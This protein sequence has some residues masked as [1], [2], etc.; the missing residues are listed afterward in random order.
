ML[1]AE[2]KEPAIYDQLYVLY[3]SGGRIEDANALLHQKIE[4]F[5]RVAEYRIQLAAH[6]VDL[7]KPIES[8]KALQFVVDNRGEFPKADMH[9][10]DYYVKTGRWDDAIKQFEQGVRY[11][12]KEKSLYQK[13]IFEAYLAQ[14]KVAAANEVLDAMLKDDPKNAEARIAKAMLRLG[15]MQDAELK[16]AIKDFQALS[17]EFPDNAEY[18]FNLG[19]AYTVMEDL[20][21]ALKELSEAIRLNPD[22]IQARI[23]AAEV[24]IEKQSFKDALQQA[25]EVLSR[26]PDHPQARLLRIGALLGQ[27]NMITARTELERLLRDR[28]DFSAAEIQLAY[29]E[30]QAKRYPEAEQILRKFYRP[31]TPDLLVLRGLATLYLARGQADRA[32]ELLNQEINSSKEPQMTSRMR[33]V[34]AETATH[35]GKADIAVQQY[36]RALPNSRRPADIYYR[37][38]SL[39]A[40]QSKVDEAIQHLQQARHLAPE[41]SSIQLSLAAMLETKGRLEEAQPLYKRVLKTDPDNA[42]ALNNLAFNLAESGGDL[43][44][45]LRLINRALKRMPSN[46]NLSD[47]LGWIYLKKKDVESALPIML[48][49]ARRFPENSTFRYHLGVALLEKGDKV[50][51]KQ[52]LLAALSSQP[53]AIEE[54]KIRLEISKVE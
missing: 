4:I 24:Y 19:R 36:E 43:D 42:V 5:P 29:L 50:Q 3:R 15:T 2:P 39:Y 27:D 52:E 32:I 53:P 20:E 46:A 30:T 6:Y 41:N 51:A 10:G 22:L 37:I 47:T 49:L 12:G 25:D 23:A 33:L 8:A 34:L 21:S 17:S 9:V 48:N 1:E 26:T 45:A 54:R 16:T 13:R 44:E 28:P 7:R 11:D 38:S 35:A 14:G 31:G 40:S 18:R